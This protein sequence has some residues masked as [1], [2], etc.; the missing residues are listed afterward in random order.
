[1]FSPSPATVGTCGD[2]IGGGIGMLGAG[3]DESGLGIAT[4]GG[5]RLGGTATG[6]ATVSYTHLRAHET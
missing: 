3:I 1:M 4:G 6:A 2:G 5:G